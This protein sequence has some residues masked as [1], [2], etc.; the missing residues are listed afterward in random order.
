MRRGRVQALLGV[1]AVLVLVN[2]LLVVL[3]TRG[4]S[5]AASNVKYHVVV[6]TGLQPKAIE[7]ALNKE[8]GELVTTLGSYAIFRQSK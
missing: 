1:I 4:S 3:L 6:L 8:T 5:Y 2:V 7:T